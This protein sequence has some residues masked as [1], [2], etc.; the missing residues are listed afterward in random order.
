MKVRDPYHEGSS[1]YHAGIKRSA[2]PYHMAESAHDTWDEGWE[3]AEQADRD[4]SD[5]E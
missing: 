4:G 2:N 5:P 1:A 3:D